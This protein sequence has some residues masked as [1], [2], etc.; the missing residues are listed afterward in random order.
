MRL[1]LTLLLK[2]WM[3]VPPALRYAV[4]CVPLVI[5]GIAFFIEWD[6]M[7]LVGG[8]IASVVLFVF[9]QPTKEEKSGY[10]F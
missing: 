4:A 2:T 10:N 8:L 5:C 6:W 3:T 7:Y 1:I 9:A